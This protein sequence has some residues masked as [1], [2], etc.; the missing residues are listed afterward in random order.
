MT[1]P[2]QKVKTP[3]KR[4]EDHQRATTVRFLTK[5]SPLTLFQGLSSETLELDLPSSVDQPL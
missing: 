2:T 5:F 1:S 4:S 3:K